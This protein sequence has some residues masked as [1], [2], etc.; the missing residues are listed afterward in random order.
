MANTSKAASKSKST[1]NTG[2]K[3]PLTPSEALADVIGNTPLPRTEITKKIWD[4][5][6][7]HNL[8]DTKDKR[9]INA[10]EKLK[11]LFDGKSQISMFELAKVVSKHVK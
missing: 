4:Y 11:I 1:A 2:L 10:D 7:A 8:Q 6:K 3:A 9:M 5:I